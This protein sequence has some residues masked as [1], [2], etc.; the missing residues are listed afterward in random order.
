MAERIRLEEQTGPPSAPLSSGTSAL[1]AEES[2]GL[3]L[4]F[5]IHAADPEG[6]EALRHARRSMLREEWTKGR[7]PGEPS[8]ED[9]IFSS[10]EVRWLVSPEQRTWCLQK[11]AELT[12]RANR[13][14]G[15]PDPSM[16]L[17][18]GTRA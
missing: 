3:L 6:L 12:A 2:P 10:T 9:A 15:N 13:A 16:C 11:L 4:C 5:R 18:G 17:R 1:V 14:H 8:L 7:E